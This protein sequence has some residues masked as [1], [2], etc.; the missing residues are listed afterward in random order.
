MYSDCGGGSLMASACIVFVWRGT[1]VVGKVRNCRRSWD[2]VVT[3]CRIYS[4]VPFISRGFEV[5][6]V[7]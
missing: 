5:L 2:G 1:K 6:T 7:H 4:V 3:Y